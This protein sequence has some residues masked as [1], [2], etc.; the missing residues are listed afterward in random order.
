MDVQKIRHFNRY[1][2]RILGIF[3]KKF[4]GVDFSVTD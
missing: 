2:A 1:Y 3:D 4:L